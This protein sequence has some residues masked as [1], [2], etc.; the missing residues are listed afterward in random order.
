MNKVSHFLINENNNIIL[1][2]QYKDTHQIDSFY[3]C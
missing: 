2:D 3:Q 1:I